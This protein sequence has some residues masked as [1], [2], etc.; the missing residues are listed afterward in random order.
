MASARAPMALADARALPRSHSLNRV[1]RPVSEA[2]GV[3]SPAPRKCNTKSVVYNS[4]VT[5]L[6]GIYVLYKDVPLRRYRRIA[7]KSE[8]SPS[9]IEFF[10]EITEGAP[11]DLENSD[12]QVVPC[13]TRSEAMAK[14]EQERESSL[15]SGW[16][17]YPDASL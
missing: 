17:E 11:F 12:L 10:V 9:Q 7:A 8:E 2:H 16:R 4:R 5:T 3:S 14:A 1:S 13:S 15:N 6:D